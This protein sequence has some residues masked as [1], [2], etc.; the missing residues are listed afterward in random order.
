VTD[1]KN[2]L[3]ARMLSYAEDGETE[4]DWPSFLVSWPLPASLLPACQLSLF[5]SV[6]SICVAVAQKLTWFLTVVPH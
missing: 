1:H 4:L 5:H 6:L 3:A 2:E